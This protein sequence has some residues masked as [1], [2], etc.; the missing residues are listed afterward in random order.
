MSTSSFSTTTCR[1]LAAPSLSWSALLTILL[2]LS[3]T[4]SK[5]VT[6]HL[7]SRSTNRNKYISQQIHAARD[8]HVQNT[9]RQI[10]RSHEAFHNR[11]DRE[12][13][14]ATTNT[15]TATPIPVCLL[16][17]TTTSVNFDTSDSFNINIFGTN[18][19]DTTCTCV[20][21]NNRGEILTEINQL[22]ITN[23]TGWVNGFNALIGELSSYSNY[24][25]TNACD[26]CFMTNDGTTSCAIFSTSES[27]SVQNRPGDFT[28]QQISTNNVTQQDVFDLIG[29][30]TFYSSDCIVYTTPE[31]YK[32]NELCFTINFDGIPSDTNDIIC[33]ITYSDVLC[34]SCIIPSLPA[35]TNA[36]SDEGDCVIADCTNIDTNAMIDTCNG[37]GLV[38][39]F[40]Y[41][42][43][44][45][46]SIDSSTFTVGSTGACQIDAIVPTSA[47]IVVPTPATEATPTITPVT[48]DVDAPMTQP[49]IAP[50]ASSPVA[51][52]P[53]PVPLPTSGSIDR[54][55][56]AS[57]MKFFSSGIMVY[58]GVFVL[59]QLL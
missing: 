38:G 36:T 25:C 53:D 15:P 11:N 50:T 29:S 32:D 58:G 55:V 22:D 19:F 46:S 49:V 10:E 59:A 8:E 1:R 41:L 16:D 5:F 27:S 14:S 24:S 39:P 3:E 21:E 2:L 23:I 12:L 35:G 28:F 20:E 43:L 9:L 37:I 7:L 26:S 40:A 47:P 33:N 31:S 34:N 42:A 17:G 4:S 6:C 54:P 51:A 48:A 45:R 57:H 44:D 13:Q 56:I 52:V 18:V 30:A